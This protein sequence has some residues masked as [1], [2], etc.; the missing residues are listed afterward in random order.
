MSYCPPSPKCTIVRPT[1]PNASKK[2]A[3]EPS[4][5]HLA[6]IADGSYE[7][8]YPS[9]WYVGEKK[10]KQGEVCKVWKHLKLPSWSPEQLD[11]ASVETLQ[12]HAWRFIV[13][14]REKSFSSKQRAELSQSI[15]EDKRR[16][17]QFIKDHD[18]R[19]PYEVRKHRN[20]AN[21][22]AKRSAGGKFTCTGTVRKYDL[23]GV[24]SRKKKKSPDEIRKEAGKLRRKAC[25]AAVKEAEETVMFI[26]KQKAAVLMAS[27]GLN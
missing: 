25:K 20:S 15:D 21:L 11:A 24:N 17:A 5:F 22:R 8:G 10:S 1:G 12:E 27:E 14:A 23:S 19:T 16:L 13:E 26:L 9:R 2:A 18:G 4:N 6:H 3:T 7:H